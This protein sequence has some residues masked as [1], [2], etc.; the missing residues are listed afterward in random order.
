MHR[1]VGK[2]YVQTWKIK[3]GA[4]TSRDLA[5]GIRVNIE[6]EGT[7]RKD[8]LTISCLDHIDVYIFSNT[9]PWP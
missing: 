8:L 6:F 4:K 2:F 3:F 5:L 9:L 1:L 7:W